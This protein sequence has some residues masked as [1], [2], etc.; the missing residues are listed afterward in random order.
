VSIAFD[1]LIG[2]D[3][4]CSLIENTSE[5]RQGG[6]LINQAELSLSRCPDVAIDLQAS[7]STAEANG[8]INYDVVLTNNESM[9]VP[10]LGIVVQI[11][12]GTMYVADSI[13]LIDASYNGVLDRVEWTH[14]AAPVREAGVTRLG[15]AIKP[16][17]LHLSRRARFRKPAPRRI[18]SRVRTHIR[19]EFWA[20]IA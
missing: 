15:P 14:D 13:D 5:L 12:D 10:G 1:V 2:V 3:A 8:Q 9:P 20:G 4:G 19:H 16:D 6:M 18:R 17:S 7:S 11:P